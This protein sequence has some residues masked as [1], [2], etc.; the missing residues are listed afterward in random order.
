V[1]APR[2]ALLENKIRQTDLQPALYKDPISHVDSTSE[3]EYRGIDCPFAAKGA[4]LASS[5]CRLETLTN[6]YYFSVCN[7]LNRLSLR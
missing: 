7:N 6:Y 5:L 2:I 1:S 4:D 3:E